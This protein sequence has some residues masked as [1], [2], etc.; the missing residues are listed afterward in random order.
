[1]AETFLTPPFLV[2]PG[3]SPPDSPAYP[4]IAIL[5]D[6]TL[7]ARGKD[8]DGLTADGPVPGDW[9]PYLLE[10]PL[11]CPGGSPPATAEGWYA[12][13]WA[14]DAVAAAAYRG[15]P[16][17]L[18]RAADACYGIELR[19]SLPECAWRDL[20]YARARVA[21]AW[22]GRAAG[23]RLLLVVPKDKRDDVTGALK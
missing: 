18:G 4:G 16:E 2:D 9:K 20:A 14:A 17:A 13:L 3:L 7:R 6:G 23:G 21:G 10:V 19:T 15:D 8:R 1:M 22:G 5:F 12:L 11:D